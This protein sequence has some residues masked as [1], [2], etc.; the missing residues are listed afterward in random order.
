MTLTRLNAQGVKVCGRVVVS[1][2]LVVLWLFLYSPDSLGQAL[3]SSGMNSG[4]QSNLVGYVTN[5]VAVMAQYQR[6]HT[7]IHPDP[8]RPPFDKPEF[9]K[10]RRVIQIPFTNTVFDH[11]LPDSL[12]N[13]LWTNLLALTNGRN[14]QIWSLR[15]RSPE[16][17]KKPPFVAWNRSGLLWGLSGMTGLSPSWEGESNPGQIPITA[18]TKR[19]GYTR[20]HSMGPEGFRASFRGKKV[21]FAGENNVLTQVEIVREVVRT[22]KAGAPFDYTVVLFDRDLP[23]LIR[24]LRVLDPGVW[25]ELFTK[26]PEGAPVPVVL[27]EQGG[28]L[29]ANLP[30]FRVDSW[31]GGD[32]GSPNLV[33]YGNEL[34]FYGGRSTSGPSSQMQADMDELCKLEDLK[35]KHYQMSWVQLQVGKEAR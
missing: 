2:L 14:S 6:F 31:K 9:D 5:G 16:W 30:G 33:L 17:P 34:V 29:S 27:V 11:F 25:A 12:Q 3:E 7:K 32:S 23:N 24:P 4:S 35:A 18:L 26:L 8:T 10:Y 13:L 19:H 1:L 15:K 21:W 20:G 28:H 22:S